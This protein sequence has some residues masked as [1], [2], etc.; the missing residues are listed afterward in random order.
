MV[1]LPV[2]LSVVWDSVVILEGTSC[3]STLLGLLVEVV[4]FSLNRK[5]TNQLINIYSFVPG[6]I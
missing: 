3:F 2:F 6:A 5:Q 4:L 1:L